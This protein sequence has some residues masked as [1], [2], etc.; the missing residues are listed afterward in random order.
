MPQPVIAI[1][2]I[3]KTNKK[4]FLLS[5]QYEIIT[6][7]SE[8]LDETTDEDGFACDDLA[9]L[10]AWVHTVLQKAMQR[11]DLQIEAVNVSAYG[12]SFVHLDKT[13]KPVTPLYNYLKP[14]PENLHQQFYMQYGPEE[15]WSLVTASPILGNLN[16]GLQLYWLKYEQPQIFRKIAVSLHLPQYISYLISGKTV[17]EVTSIGC[18]TGLWDFEKKQYHE[19]V[20]K[21]NI[22]SFFPPITDPAVITEVKFEGKAIKAGTGMH[23]SSAALVPYLASFSEPFILV[24]TGT[25]CISLNP[26]NQEILTQDELKKDCLCYLTYRGRPVKASRIFAGYEH[27][28]ETKKI[29]AHFGVQDDFYKMVKFDPRI[30]Q[31]TANKAEERNKNRAPGVSKFSERLPGDFSSFVDAYHQ[32]VYDIVEEQ[33]SSTA[34]ILSHQPPRRIFVDGGFAKNELYMYMLAHAFPQQEVYAASVSQA[35]A[36][37]AALAIHAAWNPQPVRG[38]IVQLKYY[39]ALL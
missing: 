9:A 32:L 13:G 4:F 39:K 27:E 37:G 35:T 16:S 26:F 8:Q 25:W 19:W 22:H 14:F 29:A 21:E 34:L 10:T 38:D 1:F 28:A 5:Q 20:Q 17:S 31:Q 7:H 2:D 33:R 23:D 18:H 30:Y 24:S 12:A 6:E 36:I 15:E 11:D 3:G